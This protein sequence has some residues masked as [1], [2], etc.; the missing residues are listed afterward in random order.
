MPRAGGEETQ[1]TATAA[2]TAAPTAVPAASG[3]AAPATG[4]ETVFLPWALMLCVGGALLAALL[5]GRHTR[6]HK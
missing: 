2:P 1:P 5:I 3:P 6:Q 4:D